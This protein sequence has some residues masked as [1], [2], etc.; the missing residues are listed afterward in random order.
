MRRLKRSIGL[1][2]TAAGHRLAP[3]PAAVPVEVT[4]RVPAPVA[5]L[6]EVA[7]IQRALLVAAGADHAA[8]NIH[9]RSGRR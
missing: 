7:R 4:V 5:H 1:R 3:P 2:L 8:R 9:A 6:D